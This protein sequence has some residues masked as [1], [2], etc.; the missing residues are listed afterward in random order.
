MIH[1]Y[2]RNPT[3]SGSANQALNTELHLKALRDPRGLNAVKEDG[4]ANK[5]NAI[6]GGSGLGST[7]SSGGN[8]PTNGDSYQVSVLLPVQKDFVD[9]N[10]V[11]YGTDG[12]EEAGNERCTS[13]ATGGESIHMGKRLSGER[14]VCRGHILGAYKRRN[15]GDHAVAIQRLELIANA[16][17]ML[18]FEATEEEEG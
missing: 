16:L 17:G 2:R 10:G 5:R 8:S 14:R 3:P 11:V 7:S 4:Y 13:S 6:Y 18:M 15:T 12:C 1:S 9:E